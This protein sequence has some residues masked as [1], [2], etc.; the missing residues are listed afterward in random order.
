[1]NTFLSNHWGSTNQNVRPSCRS[2][3]V[4]R[5]SPTGRSCLGGVLPSV[6]AELLFTAFQAAFRSK[7]TDC[8]SLRKTPHSQHSIPNGK[9]LSYQRAGSGQVPYF[10]LGKNVYRLGHVGSSK[11]LKNNETCTNLESVDLSSLAGSNAN[12]VFRSINKRTPWFGD[13]NKD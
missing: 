10:F 6:G 7:A 11:N 4:C 8:C 2:C 1:M 13:I 5:T 3:R 9:L 12:P